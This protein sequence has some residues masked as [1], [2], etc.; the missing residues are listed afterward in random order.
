MNPIN[1]V[2][3][4]LDGTL[5][6]NNEELEDWARER[7]QELLQPIQA[8][9]LIRNLPQILAHL[10]S[11]TSAGSRAESSAD[12]SLFLRGLIPG[13]T[14][15]AIE[16]I[17]EM[18][19]SW[20]Q[21][22]QLTPDAS[23]LLDALD[24]AAVPYGV[25]TNA[26]RSQRIKTFSLGLDARSDCIFISGEFGVNKPDPSIFQAAATCLGVPCGQILFVGDSPENDI[27]GAHSAGMQAA[28]LR[29]GR[30]WPEEHAGQEPDYV[31]ERLMEVTAVVSR[32]S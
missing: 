15:P 32:K 18:Y 3:F 13:L 9:E 2:L 17:T 22:V 23:E 26:P 28:W 1:A 11:R 25:V 24:S 16:F 5:Y 6:E 21:H 20:L 30:L 27:T 12:R 4:D 19:E 8:E 7:A 31:I 10:E 14:A 29:H